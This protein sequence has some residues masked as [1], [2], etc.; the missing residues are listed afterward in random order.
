M[1]CSN[2]AHYRSNTV[3]GTNQY[4]YFLTVEKLNQ[5]NQC[6]YLLLVRKGRI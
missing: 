1:V 5:S 6:L 2:F 3:D 4:C